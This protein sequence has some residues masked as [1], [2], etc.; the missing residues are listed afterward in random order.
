MGFLKNAIKSGISEGISKGINK[1]INDAVGA[2]V[3]K[4]VTPVA[5]KWAGKMAENIDQSLGTAGEALDSSREAALS[6]GEAER[7]MP[8]GFGFAHLSA[9]LA[10][11]QTAAEEY[12]TELSKNLKECPQCGE[13]VPA[14]NTF[15]P[16]CGTRLPETTMAEAY[17]CRQC[18]T[19][20]NMDTRFCQKCGAVLPCYEEEYEREKAEREASEAAERQAAADAEAAEAARQAKIEEAKAGVNALKNKAAGLGGVA[21]DKTLDAAASLFGKFRK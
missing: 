11:A 17:T 7:P 18:G 14:S 21:A 4:A 9:S 5:D 16:H 12:A 19:Q 15:C 13:A 10:Q 2:A 3:N 20:N 1:G 6:V 8:A